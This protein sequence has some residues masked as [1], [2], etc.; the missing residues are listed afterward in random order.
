MIRSTKNFLFII[1][2]QARL[3]LFMALGLL[4]II[5]ANK[6]LALQT[7]APSDF[8]VF[9]EIKDSKGRAL[10]HILG[11]NHDV[12]IDD[13][14]LPVEI[15]E[16]LDQAVTGLLEAVL[17]KGVRRKTAFAAMT[18]H[19]LR[20]LPK[21][22]GGLSLSFFLGEEL[23]RALF[24]YF[25]ARFNQYDT[26]RALREA[27]KKFYGV[28]VL[29][30]DDFNH[31]APRLII[32]ID[33]HI[34]SLAS[35]QD[36]LERGL[37]RDK[38]VGEISRPS[39]IDLPPFLSGPL[40]GQCPLE[41]NKMDDYI[42]NRL[43]CSGKSIYPIEKDFGAARRQLPF[44]SFNALPYV[45]SLSL[46]A[47]FLQQQNVDAKLETAAASWIN[48]WNTQIKR[49]HLS[50]FN[51]FTGGFHQCSQQ[52]KRK[53]LEETVNDFINSCEGRELS[54]DLIQSFY[55]LKITEWINFFESLIT[56]G[57]MPPIPASQEEIQENLF[58]ECF[59]D[60]EYNTNI[61][62]RK[63]QINR[64]IERLLYE[65]IF[66][67]DSDMVENM[68]PFLERGGVFAFVGALHLPGI[69]RQLESL[70]FYVLPVP[71]SSPVTALPCGAQ[72]TQE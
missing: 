62:E 39:S 8:D 9:Y 70:G 45:E 4:S 52:D 71:L 13:S 15:K 58:L 35:I 30:Y 23:T 7:E 49:Y 24:H 36:P 47:A 29:N 21:I 42:K 27:Y 67:R 68:L 54:I 33:D 28:D 72:E 19:F 10:G 57:E 3:C 64:H 34:S 22:E 65:G 61:V 26:D 41:K 18:D 14:S 1:A 66:K 50:C 5:L 2:P 38:I 20:V 12:C 25:E 6:A 44:I 16:A 32:K 46:N 60:Q 59:P 43:L 48:F 55:D 53:L 40:E 17:P 11:T 37:I 56:S 69:K 63:T 31:L 51:I